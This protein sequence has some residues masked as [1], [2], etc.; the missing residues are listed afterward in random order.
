MY[1]IWTKIDRGMRFDIACD[2]DGQSMV[3]YVY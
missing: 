1:D 2:N 3:N